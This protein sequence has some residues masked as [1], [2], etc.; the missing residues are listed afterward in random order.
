LSGYG[1]AQP[2]NPHTAATKVTKASSSDMRRLKIGKS[3]DWPAGPWPRPPMGA[4]LMYRPVPAQSCGD[5]GVG[6]RIH[7]RL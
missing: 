7:A 4:T 1:I 2:V 5:P 3:A 6:L